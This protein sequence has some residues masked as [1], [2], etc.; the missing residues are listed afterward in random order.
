[1]PSHKKTAKIAAAQARV[2]E[3]ISRVKN[4]FSLAAAPENT[5]ARAAALLEN[6]EQAETSLET[7]RKHLKNQGGEVEEL[8]LYALLSTTKKQVGEAIKTQ[9]LA[10]AKKIADNLNAP[11]RPLSPDDSEDWGMHQ[12]LKLKDALQKAGFSD[13]Y[14]GLKQIG[15][16]QKDW[17]SPKPAP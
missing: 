4:L 16:S 5:G 7:A 6:V 1:M 2:D 11:Y 14:A 13:L 10:E 8:D 12:R 17:D 9:Y 3:I 15:I